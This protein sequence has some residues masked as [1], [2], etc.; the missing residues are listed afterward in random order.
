M[1]RKYHGDGVRVCSIPAVIGI[2]GNYSNSKQTQCCKIRK[3]KN[4]KVYISINVSINSQTITVY[5]NDIAIFL[6]KGTLK[7]N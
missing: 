7:S 4:K 5:N 6:L 2:E 1:P 3:K